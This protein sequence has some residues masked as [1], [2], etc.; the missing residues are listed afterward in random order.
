VSVS[1]DPDFDSA[2]FSPTDFLTETGPPDFDPDDFESDDFYA[3]GNSVIELDQGITLVLDE[4]YTLSCVLPDGT[5]EDRTV[6][7]TSDDA[8][9]TELRVEPAF[10]K[11]PL[12]GAMWVVTGSNV[13]PRKFRV[14]GV[15]EVEKNIF[16]VSA[17]LHD[18]TKYA[19]V[20]LGVDIPEQTNNK[21]KTGAISPPSNLS[22]REYLYEGV[23]GLVN[24]AVIVSWSASPDSRARFYE[25]QVQRPDTSFYQTISTNSE[26]SIHLNNVSEGVYSFRVRALDSIGISSD[27]ETE[28][29]TLEGLSGAPEDVTS[30]R[31]NNVG[32][33]SNLTWT[34]VT[35]L[36]L[37]H[38]IIKFSS[39]TAGAT[40][41]DGIVIAPRVPAGSEY[42][43]VP[44][45]IGTY[46]IKAV[47]SS[48]K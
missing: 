35:D 34:A 48:D 31:I 14:V 38:Y 45:L 37:S 6:T 10:S 29:F 7:T 21:K 33:Q 22:K 15:S 27:W 44:T 4:T 46:M 30:F 2:D 43:T 25:I 19:R 32:A 17:M 8:L 26:L 13:A 20:E 12:V 47:D 40:W 41:G 1:A 24:S 16:E 18:T 42:W 9:H 36:D 11:A 5:I 3:E 28:S 39:L 23:N